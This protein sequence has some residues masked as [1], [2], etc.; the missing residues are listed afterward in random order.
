MATPLP[1]H[2]LPG[3]TVHLDGIP[4]RRK[5]IDPNCVYPPL[6]NLPVG[7]AVSKEDLERRA[8]LA[9]IAIRGHQWTRPTLP[10]FLRSHCA[11]FLAVSVRRDWPG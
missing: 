2:M 9:G 1:A 4:I 8:R 10:L 3:G 6:H 7:L 5:A 11:R